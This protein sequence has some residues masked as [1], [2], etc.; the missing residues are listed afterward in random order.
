MAQQHNPDRGNW[1]SRDEGHGSDDRRGGSQGGAPRSSWESQQ[2]SFSERGDQMGGY[3]TGSDR[4]YGGGQGNYG[5][6][7]SGDDWGRNQGGTDWRSAPGGYGRDTADRERGPQGGRGFS[8]PGP[9]G[10]YDQASYER[11]SQGF[12]GR[13]LQAHERFGNEDVFSQGSRDE[14]QGWQGERQGQGG[15][16]VAAGHEQHHFDPDYHQWRSEQLRNLDEDYRSWRQERYKKFSDEFN[17]W[18]AGRNRGGPSSGS[19]STG[20]TGAEPAGG[21]HGASTAA[22]G[23]GSGPSTAAS[24]TSGLTG[25][26]PTSGEPK[27]K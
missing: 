11:G 15:Y 1:S 2:S 9:R 22:T 25:S 23:A 12:R 18:R 3:Y 26:S 27:S 5:S 17:S 20:S 24:G 4:N 7:R 8:D 6:G 14:R 21:S 13:G 16:G 10:T 19:G